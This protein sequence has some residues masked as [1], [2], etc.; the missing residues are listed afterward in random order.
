ANAIFAASQQEEK[1]V[2]AYCDGLMAAAAY[3][4]GSAA[5]RI[6]IS[7]QTVQVGSIGVV[8]THV[9]YSEW[10]KKAG[11]KTTE[12]YAGKYKRIA[13]EYK[14]LSKEGREY[15]QEHVDYYY[16]VFANAVS[17][18]RQNLDIPEDGVISWA[19]GKIFVGK[20]SIENGLVDGDSTL[21]ELISRFSEGG[22]IPLVREQINDDIL[23]RT[24]NGTHD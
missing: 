4:I 21:E 5:N 3:W 2:V 8:A 1:P 15:M 18:H 16:S 13:S 9:D 12:I 22:R 6:Y 10:E 23:R 19:D 20:Q 7:G 24:K 17:R 11:V 14:P